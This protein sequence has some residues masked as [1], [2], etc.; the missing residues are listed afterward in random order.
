MPAITRSQSKKLASGMQATSITK[1]A[2][3]ASTSRLPCNKKQVIP[4]KNTYKIRC[5]AEY[6]D[7]ACEVVS[8]LH[9]LD[10]LNQ[11]LTDLH[12]N[13]ESVEQD[14]TEYNKTYFKI[15]SILLDKY[16]R[17]C[18]EIYM[19]NLFPIYCKNGLELIQLPINSVPI[20][21][22]PINSNVSN[23]SGCNLFGSIEEKVFYNCNA[24]GFWSYADKIE[25]NPTTNATEQNKIKMVR[26]MHKLALSSFSQFKK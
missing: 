12:K 26:H 3:R 25:Q 9:Y 1:P 2:K 20:N 21:S 15:L 19:F 23:D 16:I 6:E 10:L 4:T 13:L 14:S 11:T 7:D 8:F 22:V 5:S 17:L 18:N 24:V